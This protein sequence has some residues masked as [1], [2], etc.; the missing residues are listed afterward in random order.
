MH[1]AV[2]GPGHYLKTEEKGD[3]SKA[4]IKYGDKMTYLDEIIKQNKREKTPAP[5]Q[6]NVVKTLKEE[7][8]E[9]KKLAS[10]KINVPDRISYLDEVQY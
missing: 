1:S 10:K 4:K 9:A 7:E 8:G 5:G 2:P 6:Y 3:K